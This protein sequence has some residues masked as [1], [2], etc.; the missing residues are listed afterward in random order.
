M[1]AQESRT[2]RI[3]MRG[4]DG[5][6]PREHELFQQA[7]ANGIGVDV[8]NTVAAVLATHGRIVQLKLIQDQV[9]LL[10]DNAAHQDHRI[11]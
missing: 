4:V 9:R 6:V 10:L 7:L 5:D 11:M 2:P 1:A 8:E 3:E